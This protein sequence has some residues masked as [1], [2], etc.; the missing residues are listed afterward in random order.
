MKQAHVFIVVLA[1]AL[2][3]GCD[4]SLVQPR[5]QLITATDGKIYRLDIKTGTV[6]YVTPSGMGLLTDHVPILRVGEYYQM[7]DAKDDT[8]FLKYLGNGG[9]EKG[10]WAIRKEPQ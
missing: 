7:A 4:W 9:F 1:V 6:H 2:L 10:K 8:K 3:S 5:Y